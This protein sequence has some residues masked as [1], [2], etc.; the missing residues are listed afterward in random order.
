MFDLAD[1]EG[2]VR[3]RKPKSSALGDY[4]PRLP[5]DPDYGQDRHTAVPQPKRRSKKSKVNLDSGEMIQLHKQLLAAYTTELDRQS[6]NRGE[7]ASDEDF[8]DSIQWTEE[9]A[10]TLRDRGQVPLVYNVISTSCDW[11]C[12]TEKRARTDFKVL[13][14]RK[15][16]AKPAQKKT[17]LMKYLSDVNREP[18]HVSRAFEDAVKVGIGW[19]EDGFDADGQEEPLYSRYENWRNMLYDSAATDLS[20]DDARYIFR[21]KWV[22]LDIAIALFPEREAMLRQTAINSEDFI[23][24][25]DY[26]DE[27][28]DAQEMALEMAGQS[29]ASGR[30]NNPDFKRQRVRIVEAWFRRP[31]F[32]GRMKGGT[33]HGELFDAFSDAHKEE[34]ASG[35]A[36]LVERVTMRVHVALFTHAGML[37][38]SESP[39][40]HNK[41]PFTPIWAYRRGRDGAPYGVIRRL[42][43]IQVDINKRAS[44]ALHILSTS[45]IIMDSDALPDDMTFEEF[46]EEVS[47][48][49]A[50][51]RKRPGRELQLNADRDLAQWHLELMSRSIAMIQQTSGVT[52]ELLGRR[53]NA[54]S[55]IAIQRRQDQG[56]LATAKL[57]DNLL[58]ANQLHG[59]KELSNIE[60]FMDEQKQFRITNMRGRPEY[61]TVN[62]GLPENDIVRSKADFV[63]SESAWHATVR[64]A[65]AAELLQAMTHLPPE[66]SVLLLD[67]VVEN[68]DLPNREEIVKRI[69]S[70]TG[71][72]DPD[73]EELSPEEQAQE[74][75]KAAQQQFQMAMAQAALKKALADADKAAAAALQSQAAAEKAAAEIA[76]INVTTQKTALDT[77]GEALALP[78]AT[79]VADYILKESGFVSQTDKDAARLATLEAAQRQAEQPGLTGPAGPPQPSQGPQGPQPPSPNGARPPAGL[80]Q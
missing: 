69:R 80:M 7:M 35:D 40:R 38:F 4:G 65:A 49:D 29:I 27:A 70:V 52:D 32:S 66:V 75:A 79:E 68:M 34:L 73:A 9:D 3:R 44:K 5:E 10:Q 53:T 78:A 56:S 50:I 23:G 22:D 21:S 19:L 67:M 18:F 6:E 63:I 33:F 74:Q 58:Y 25:D 64:E 14:R 37:W 24:I 77:A 15:E 42:K 30:V 36:E 45:K 46:Q 31:V 28:M 71:M 61:V 47:R 57:F 26:G 43:D 55:G 76:G 59:E 41:F 39:Y 51:I 17:A 48:P 60:Q 62:D 16:E 2:S 72:R 1:K 54:T 8:Y 11:I 13:P 12:G 20:L